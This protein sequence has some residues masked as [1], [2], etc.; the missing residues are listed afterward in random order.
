MD[1]SNLIW[2]IVTVCTVVVVGLFGRKSRAVFNSQSA[3][4][5]EQLEGEKL[6]TEFSFLDEL[7]L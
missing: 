1:I 7:S 3:P 6:M 4:G 2:S 5:L